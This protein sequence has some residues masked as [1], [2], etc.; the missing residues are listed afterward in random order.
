M[1]KHASILANWIQRKDSYA[2]TPKDTYKFSLIYRGSI[3]GY[4]TN[5]IRSK[6]HRYRKSDCVLIIKTNKN[7]S[8]IG[9]YNPLGW[10]YNKDINGDR[11]DL[12]DFKISRVVNEDRAI[13]ESKYHNIPLN[14]GNSDLVIY[15]KSGKIV[16][17]VAN[18]L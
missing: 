1:P 11:N 16:I 14:F 6:C 15:Y 5:I 17:L 10:R 4:N 12:N 7:D 2:R 13:C 8:I 3:D 18:N 9:G